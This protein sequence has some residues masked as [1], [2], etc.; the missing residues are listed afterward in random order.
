MRGEGALSKI[1]AKRFRL[2]AFLGCVRYLDLRQVLGVES[3][4]GSQEQVTGCWSVGLAVTTV[5]AAAE[6]GNDS[7][8]LFERTFVVR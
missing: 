4:V 7:I 5:T 2:V 8:S 1:L 6:A 3:Q